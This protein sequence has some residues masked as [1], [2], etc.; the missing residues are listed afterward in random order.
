[1]AAIIDMVLVG[2]EEL[3]AITQKYPEAAITPI[4][5]STGLI[6]RFRIIIPNEDE[7]GW[8]KFLVAN[9]IAMSSKNFYSRL[10]SDLM[11]AQTI[12]ATP[13]SADTDEKR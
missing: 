2:P 9:S 12:K 8:Y 1:V 10:K 5:P 7:E 4:H 11:F 6:R 3:V 13:P